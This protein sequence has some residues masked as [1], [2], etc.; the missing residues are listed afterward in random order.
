MEREPRMRDKGRSTTRARRMGGRRGGREGRTMPRG[1]ERGDR[2]P[3]RNANQEESKGLRSERGR[4][5]R[6]VNVGAVP[7]R[8]T[9]TPGIR[10]G[11]MLRERCSSDEVEPLTLAQ[12]DPRPLDKRRSRPGRMQPSRNA[13]ASEFP[14]LFIRSKQGVRSSARMAARVSLRET[15]SVKLHHVMQRDSPP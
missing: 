14:F 8:W 5:P 9:S 1:K 4:S 7:R 13:N 6:A 2:P 11:G 12:S 10:A 15:P 3:T